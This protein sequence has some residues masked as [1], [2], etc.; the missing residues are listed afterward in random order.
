MKLQIKFLIYIIS[1]HLG[2]LVLSYYLFRK[3]VVIFCIVEIL[4]AISI[5]M[6]ILILKHYIRPFNLMNLTFRSITERDFSQRLV[7]TGN[8]EIDRMIEVLNLMIDQLRQ[9][10]TLQ[11]EQ[12]LFLEKLTEAM[13]IGLIILDGNQNIKSLNNAAE[14]IINLKKEDIIGL[15]V[16]KLNTPF[17]KIIAKMND[18]EAEILYQNGVESFRLIKAHFFDKGFHN[19]FIMIE[20]LTSELLKTEKAA[21]G[22]VIRMMSH[23]VNNTIGA[24]NS[25]INSLKFYGKYIENNHQIDYENALEVVIDRNENMNRFMNNFADVIRLPKPEM[26]IHDV[27]L[28]VLKIQKL[29]DTFCSSKDI[30]LLI[31]QSQEPLLVVFDE[32]QIEQLMVNVIK[33]AVEAITDNGTITIIVDPI[34]SELR[35]EDTGCGVPE[36]FESKSST[37]FFST[38]VG[39]QGIGLAISREIAINHNFRFFLQNRPEGG[40]IFRLHFKNS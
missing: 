16:E 8:A 14:N 23:E 34:E 37:P 1:L 3:E 22:K 13:P 5:C 2:I 4:V 6:S 24:I 27:N 12:H 26:K 19:H 40:A 15:P 20:E 39:G 17:A 38:K 7:K 31:N 29:M 30:S 9:E 35:V 32:H 25:I 11:Q 36:D 28:L 21:Y 18:S 10:R 33:N